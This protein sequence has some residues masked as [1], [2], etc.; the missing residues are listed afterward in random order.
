MGV[1]T[2]DKIQSR[3]NRMRKKRGGPCPRL[4][5][6]D[7]SLKIVPHPYRW[8]YKKEIYGKQWYKDAMDGWK[9]P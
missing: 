3:Y 8:R 5:L 9:K 6:Q 2:D 4:P 1:L 7:R